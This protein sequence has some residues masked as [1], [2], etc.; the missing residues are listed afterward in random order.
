[1]WSLVTIR[2]ERTSVIRFKLGEQIERMQF[3]ESRRITVQE[4]SEATAINRS[5]LSKILN[6]KGYTTS[7][8]I[9]DKLCVY[10]NCK[11]ED[12]VEYMPE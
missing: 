8:D 2:S 5:T 3:R 6:H 7:T 1:M 12:L 4:L 9:L 10:F 11:I